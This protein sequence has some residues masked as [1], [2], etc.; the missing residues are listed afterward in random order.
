MREMFIS[1]LKPDIQKLVIQ[2]KP[3]IVGEAMVLANLH[4][5]DELGVDILR[6]ATTPT[7]K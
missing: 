1:G 6:Y 3:T 2:A 5:D 4:E 7:Q